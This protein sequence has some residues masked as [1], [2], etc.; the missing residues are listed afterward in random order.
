MASRLDKL[1]EQVL[2][3]DEYDRSDVYELAE[4]AKKQLGQQARLDARLAVQKSKQATERL[5][6]RAVREARLIGGP[7]DDDDVEGVVTAVLAGRS[8]TPPEER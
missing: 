7:V 2:V 1:I 3:H 6:L 5:R 4:L 8:E